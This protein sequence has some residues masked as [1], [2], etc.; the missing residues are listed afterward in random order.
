MITCLDCIGY[1]TQGNPVLFSH[2]SITFLQVLWEITRFFLLTIE[3]S[4]IILGLA[5][6]VWPFASNSSLSPLTLPRCYRKLDYQTSYF[7]LFI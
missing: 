7:G 2:S 3:L 4:V 6:G 1:D 5:F